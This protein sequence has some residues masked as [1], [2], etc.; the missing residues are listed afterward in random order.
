MQEHAQAVIIG[1]GVGGCSIA[2]HLTRMGWKYVVVV[3]RHE[4][5]SGSTFHSAGLVGQ[6]RTSSSLTKMMR[7]STDLYRRLKDETGIDP[8]WREVGSLRIASSDERLEELKRTVGYSKA[9]GMPLEMLSPKECYELFPLMSLDGVKG[10]AY[11]K[12]DG[13][14][15]PTGLTNALAAG[16]KS[17]GAKFLAGTRVESITV[18]NNQAKEVVTDKGA[19]KTEVVVDAAGMWGG[20]IARMVGINL[21]IIPMAHLYLITKPIAGQ[22]HTLPTMRDPDLL[23]YWR[24][25]VGGLLTG[26]YERHP[27]PWSLDGIPGD[28]N[29]KLLEP[30]WDRFT[31]LME[32]SIKRVPVLETAEIVQL[33]NGPEGFTPDA[34][35]LLGPTAVRGFWVACAFCAHGLA[36]AGGVGKV[37][38]E[39]IIDGHPEW[40]M[41]RLDVRRFGSQYGSQQ[42]TLARTI[43]TYAQYYDIHYPAEERQT[44]RPLRLSPAYHRLKELGAVFGE[45]GGWERPNYFAV[46][47]KDARHGHE[48]KGWGR[49]NWSPAV[50]VEHLAARERAG[51]FDETSFS[52]IEVLGPGACAF[53]Q[54]LCANDV[55]RPVGAVV[56][57]Q[58]LNPRGGI[59]CDFTVTRLADDRYM[60]VTGTA[61]GTHDV[62]WLRLNAP[63]DGSVYINDVTSSRA[64]FGLWGPRARDILRKVTRDDVSN[65]AFPYLTAKPITIGN[66]PALALRV[67]YVGEL[68]WEFYAPMEYGQPLWDTLWQAGAEFGMVAAGYKAIESMRLEKGYRYWSA[69]ITPDYTPFEAGLAF[70]VAL[71]KPADFIGK[72][73]LVEAQVKGLSQKLCCMTLADPATVTLGSEPIRS[74]G[75]VVGWVTSGGFGYSVGRSIAYGYLPIELAKPETKLTIEC[76]GVEIDA[77]VE[78]EPLYDPKGEKIRA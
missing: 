10:G 62:T 52:K 44:A 30:D 12:T 40:D 46:Y 6:L 56:Y 54:R 20:D 51:L 19:I 11:L 23:V 53:L 75:K 76:F 18:V 74:N 59:E 43:E 73:A 2:Y 71:N 42:Y 32:N 60:I 13:Y 3:E 63:T 45:K 8:G 38:A 37:M 64:C 61:F 35:F 34:E 33:I 55:D 77:K 7:Y 72:K 70:A 26:G 5:T 50:G 27:A 49:H 21:P 16:A 58:M 66:I 24:E 68:G 41:W 39:W 4:L 9:F 78:K 36:G 28:F 65:A 69:D 17:R 31:P 29:F 1:G 14:I 22:P 15:D 25:E 48:P 67:T 47:E 57:T